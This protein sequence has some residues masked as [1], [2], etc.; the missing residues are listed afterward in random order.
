VKGKALTR[1]DVRAT[2]GPVDDIVIAEIIAMGATA[3][4]L[5]EARAWAASEPFINNARRPPSGRVGQLLRILEKIEEDE[6]ALL[7]RGS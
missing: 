5:A 1:A 3:E 2:I 7:A 6:E 4:E